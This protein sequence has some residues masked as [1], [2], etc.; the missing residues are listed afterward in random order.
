MELSTHTPQQVL[1]LPAAQGP[2]SRDYRMA[3][4][5][6]L[7]AEQKGSDLHITVNAPPLARIGGALTPL[8]ETHL[9]A[10]DTER[11]ARETLNPSEMETLFKERSAD[12]AVTLPSAGRFRVNAYYQRNAITMALRRLSDEI[13][14]LDQL[15]VPHAVGTFS[16]MRD[17]LVLVTGCTG[18]GKST[19]LATLIDMINTSQR[20]NIITI[21]D[22]IEYIHYNKQSIVNQRE[23]HSDVHSFADALR[24]ALRADPDVI[25][26]GEMRDLETTRIAIMAAETGHLVFSTLHS[27]DAVSSIN[28]IIGIFNPVEQE[29][30]R[31]QLSTAL[32]GVVSQQLLKRKGKEGRVLATEVMLVNPAISNLIRLGKAAQIYSVIETGVRDGMETMEQ[33][34]LRLVREGAI[35][36]ETAL[37]STKNAAALTQRM[38]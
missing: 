7:S 17:G 33:S 9:T 1:P 37:R 31:E 5:L 15:G 16:K 21:E 36:K 10:E 14:S 12:L 38:G 32:K 4:L 30:V 19:T 35:D 2:S 25:L 22:P 28:R 20:S 23:V 34:L 11:L 24:A 29:Q 26:V 6:M 8:G 18:S 27:R 13:L 3:D